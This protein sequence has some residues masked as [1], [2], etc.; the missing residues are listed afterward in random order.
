MD[1]YENITL[2][3]SDGSNF[4]VTSTEVDRMT[5]FA[6]I[7][8]VELYSGNSSTCTSATHNEHSSLNIVLKV[9]TPSI[10]LDHERLGH[11]SAARLRLMGISYSSGK[12]HECR[13]GKQ[14]RLPFRSLTLIATVKLERVYS[15]LCYVTPISFG[16]AKYFITFTDEL[17]RYCWI[18]LIPDKSS[19][20]ILRIL[21]VWSALVQNQSGTR[22]QYLRTDQ[23]SEYTGETL[24]T[25][26]T[27]LE[28]N[29]ITHETTSAHSSASNGIAERMNRTLMNMVRPMLLKSKLPSPFWAEALNTAVKIRNRLP[30]SSL[31]NHIS[32][33]EAWFG[34]VPSIKHFRQ[35]GCLA[36]VTVHKP[37][38]KVDTRAIQGCLLGYKGTS[39]YRVYL[40]DTQKVVTSKHVTFMENQ[41]LDPIIFSD[42]PYA[43]RPLLVPEKYTSMELY[44]DSDDEDEEDIPESAPL[45]PVPQYLPPVRSEE[46]SQLPATEQ[47]RWPIPPPLLPSHEADR[48]PIETSPPRSPISRV[49]PSDSVPLSS[50]TPVPITTE[51]L[52]PPAPLR[53]SE[54]SRKPSERQIESSAGAKL[55]F[56]LATYTPSYALSI[57]P[58]SI[59][60]A[61][62]SPYATQ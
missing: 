35:F 32:P 23:G 47:P 7:S 11:A 60:E 48:H 61:M 58:R 62:S 42:I 43:D 45:P 56:A 55:T 24:K 6:D 52:P 36:Y 15:D 31:P 50:E 3:T 34:D 59:K 57:I 39:Q 12:C 1:A 27:F 29:G 53:R 37:K 40:P 41:F 8:V 2:H 30:T 13:L 4:S 17:T 51:T 22:I 20:T 33:H 5:M 25:V 38:Y 46:S 26:T 16:L 10:Q 9:N 14:T 28:D 54:R 44:D 19:A 18:Y 21:Q 49:S